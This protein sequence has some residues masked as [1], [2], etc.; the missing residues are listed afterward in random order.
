MRKNGLSQETKVFPVYVKFEAEEEGEY[1]SYRDVLRDTAIR[2]ADSLGIKI[3][4]NSAQQFASSVPTWPPFAD[5]VETMKELGRRGCERVILSNIDRDILKATISQ[6]DLQVDGFV[7]AED[8]GSYKPAEG[9]WRRFFEEYG[10]SKEKTLHVA[11][12]VYHDII[13]SSRLGIAN[14]WINRYSEPKTPDVNPT[15]TFPDL[16]SLLSLLP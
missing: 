8:V 1:K 13:P 4:Q 2:V 9:H 5:T 16:K 11:Q 3:P 14:A 12:S 15:Y 10:A 6:A 7:T